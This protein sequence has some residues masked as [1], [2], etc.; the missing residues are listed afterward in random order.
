MKFLSPSATIGVLGKGPICGANELSRLVTAQCETGLRIYKFKKTITCLFKMT[1]LLHKLHLNQSHFEFNGNRNY[2][3]I[4]YFVCP[5]IFRFPTTKRT[6]TLRQQHSTTPTT[7]PA[8]TTN[9]KTIAT[10]SKRHSR[11]N[12]CCNVLKV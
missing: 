1:F 5:N 9:P 10:S 3:S 4:I 11:H 2:S 8:T 12:E 6:K 7:T